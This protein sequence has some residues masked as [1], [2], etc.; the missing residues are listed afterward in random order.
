M[1]PQRP[2][3]FNSDTA[4]KLDRLE[5]IAALLE[6][7]ATNNRAFIAELGAAVPRKSRRPSRVLRRWRK[8]ACTCSTAV[9]GLVSLTTAIAISPRLHA[10]LRAV[11]AFVIDFAIVL[12]VGTA[13]VAM[14]TAAFVLGAPPA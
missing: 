2:H 4:A 11:F 3:V 9:R 6:R 12:G 5:L 1:R 8:L 14:L 13:A 7:D 10:A